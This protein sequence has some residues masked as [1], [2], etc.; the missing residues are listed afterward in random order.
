MAL[1]SGYVAD[2]LRRNLRCNATAS[3]P[4]TN[5][6]TAAIECSGLDVSRDEAEFEWHPDLVG[7]STGNPS[8]NRWFRNVAHGHPVVGLRVECC[9]VALLD[10]S[11]EEV[12]NHRSSAE[13]T[14]LRMSPTMDSRR[15]RGRAA[16]FAS[17]TLGY[18][19]NTLGRAERDRIID[20]A[21]E[22]QTS[23]AT[24]D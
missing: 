22:W 8:P 18:P 23:A 1:P 15:V 24:P 5:R 17:L 7:V 21:T 4:V 13:R 6:V 2:N 9:V 10:R 14:T 12:V 20:S 16:P 19:L 11:R 3:V